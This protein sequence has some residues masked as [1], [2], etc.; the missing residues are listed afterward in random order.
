[1]SD[2]TIPVG[3]VLNEPTCGDC[4]HCQAGPDTQHDVLARLCYRNPPTAFGILTQQGVAVMSVRP[5]V[6]VDTL[7]CGEFEPEE[8]EQPPTSAGMTS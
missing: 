7:A 4:I 2:R 1:M 3:D 5:Q 6:R 8:D